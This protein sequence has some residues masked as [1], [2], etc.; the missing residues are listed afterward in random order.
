M[1]VAVGLLLLGSLAACSEP[2]SGGAP[3]DVPRDDVISLEGVEIR[4]YEGANLGSVSDFRENSIAGPQQV[5]RETYRLVVS[6]LVGEPAEYT[7]SEVASDHASYKKVVTLDCVEGWS[8][9]ILWQGVLVRDILEEVAPQPTANTV[10]LRA[11]DGYSTMFPI[12]YFYDNDI[13]LAYSM[14]GVTLPPVRGF[15]FQLV[16]EDKWGY[17]WIKWVAE[18]ELSDDEN[19]QGYWESRGYSDS[20]DRDKNFY[21]GN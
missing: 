5:D 14:N 6:G 13:L 10:I 20:G 19:Y 8:V 2:P 4:E 1:T 11:V 12:E 9:T 7:Y 16:A 18:I 21:D 3:Q 15:P 17:K